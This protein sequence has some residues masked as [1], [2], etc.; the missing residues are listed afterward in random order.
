MFFV[1]FLVFICRLMEKDEIKRPSATELLDMAYLKSRQQVL[2]QTGTLTDSNI[3]LYTK[4]T[5]LLIKY[6]TNK[7]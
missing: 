4:F 7:V 1:S 5:Q 3:C 6:D 2:S